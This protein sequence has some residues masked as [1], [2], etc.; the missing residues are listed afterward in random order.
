[1]EATTVLAQLIDSVNCSRD[2][3]GDTGVAMLDGK[4]ERTR[5]AAKHL[6]QKPKQAGKTTH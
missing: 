1:M 4:L 3:L 5:A 2:E 6:Q